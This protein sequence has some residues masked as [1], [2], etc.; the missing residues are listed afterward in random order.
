MEQFS[1]FDWILD[2]VHFYLQSEN[3]DYEEGEFIN[4]HVEE[5]WTSKWKEK[6]FC[7]DLKWN[8]KE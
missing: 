1:E 3:K 8:R 5:H 7:E 2:F 6:V 4:T